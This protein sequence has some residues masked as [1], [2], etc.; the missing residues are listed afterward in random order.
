V[1]LPSSW[2]ELEQTLSHNFRRNHRK[3]R[4]RLGATLVT[5]QPGQDVGIALDTLAA[6]HQERMETS[7]RGGN[8]RKAD[9]A[10]FHHRFAGRAAHNGWLYLAFLQYEGHPIGGRY[11]FFY[12]GVYYAYQSGFDPSMADASP[13]EVLLGMVLEDL[14]GRGAHEFNFLRGPQPHKFHWTDQRR[15]TLRLEGWARTPVGHALAALDRVAAVRRRVRRGL[16]ARHDAPGDGR[17]SDGV[18]PGA[19]GPTAP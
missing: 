1:P 5:W 8:F 19:K 4:R 9:Y 6:L 15:Q 3:K 7:G 2:A 16:A 12:R 14:I 10:A 11:G 18:S 13:G 17:P